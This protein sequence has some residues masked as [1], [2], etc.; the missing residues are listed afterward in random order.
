[1]ALNRRIQVAQTA[2]PLT[3]S[4]NTGSILNIGQNNNPTIILLIDVTVAAGTTPSLTFTLNSVLP[5]GSLVAIP[6]TVAIVA[7]TAAGQARYVFHDVV[8]NNIQLNWAISGTTPSFTCNV[9]LF[10]TSPDS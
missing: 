10:L 9:D 5:D 7:I 4:G 2:T 3:A 1:M 6:P 8:D